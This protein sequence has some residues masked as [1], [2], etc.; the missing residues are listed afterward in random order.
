V[1]IVEN[2]MAVPFAGDIFAKFVPIIR[3]NK[4]MKKG[5]TKRALSDS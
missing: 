5:Y 4:R 3:R 1:N 2:F